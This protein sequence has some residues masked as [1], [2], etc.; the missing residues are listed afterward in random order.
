[1]KTKFLFIVIFL[2]LINFTVSVL[3]RENKKGKSDFPVLKGKY[4]NIEINEGGPFSMCFS[5]NGKYLIF[6]LRRSTK[7]RERGIYWISI[8]ALKINWVTSEEEVKYD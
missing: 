2:V 8:E 4:L 7:T 6:L 5:P 3:T 1:M